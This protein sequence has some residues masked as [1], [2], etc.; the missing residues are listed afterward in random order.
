MT[1]RSF[2]KSGLIWTP[3]I[4]SAGLHGSVRLASIEPEVNG[5]MGRL[6]ALGIAYTSLSVVA[7]DAAMKIAR[8]IRSKLLRWNLYCGPGLTSCAVPLLNVGGATDTFSSFVAGD[9]SEAT[10]L[11]GNLTSKFNSTGFAPDPHWASVDDCSI[12]V[13]LRTKTSAADTLIGATSG[14][15]AAVYMSIAY[16]GTTNY[17]SMFSIANASHYATGADSAGLGHYLVSRTASNSLVLYKNGVLQYSTATP[18]GTRPLEVFYV[19]CQNAT[20]VAG[21]FSD[22]AYG[23]YEISKGLTAAD[24]VVFYTAIQRANT[25][26]GRQV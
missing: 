12:G 9:Y 10:G 21:A 4:F 11:V 22:R 24:A 15:S 23:G 8:P 26:L 7:S 2:I 25:I 14:A 18:A 1:R 19:H 13:Y 6:T 16:L 3:V 17:G 20:G 5:W